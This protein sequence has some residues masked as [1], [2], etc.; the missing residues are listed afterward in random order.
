MS[1]AGYSFALSLHVSR[2]HWTLKS[3]PGESLTTLSTHPTN[4]CD[5]LICVAQVRHFVCGMS[6]LG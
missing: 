1:F 3:I 5:H 4:S 2:D 6:E